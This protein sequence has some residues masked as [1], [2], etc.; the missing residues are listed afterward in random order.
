M[1][2]MHKSPKH[3]QARIAQIEVRREAIDFA[4]GITNVFQHTM[5]AFSTEVPNSLIHMGK[6]HKNCIIQ[7]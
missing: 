5:T 7:V 4:M 1:S 2:T 3:G 6:A